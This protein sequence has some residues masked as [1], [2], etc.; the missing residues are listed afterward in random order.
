MREMVDSGKT[1][2]FQL[3]VQDRQPPCIIRGSFWPLVR[4]DSAGEQLAV[5]YRAL[6]R[7]ATIIGNPQESR[8]FGDQA[9]AT[10]GGSA[11]AVLTT[12]GLEAPTP[13]CRH[14]T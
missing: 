14:S 2:I 8:L 3:I 7:L 10:S 13:G 9:F 6:V 1:H 12:P 4:I 11:A 5:S